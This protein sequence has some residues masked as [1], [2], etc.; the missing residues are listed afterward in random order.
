MSVE[1]SDEI[2]S[3]MWE[4]INWVNVS[5]KLDNLQEELSKA[6]KKR[7]FKEVSY[8]QKKIVRDIDIKCL[9]VRHV[10]LSSSGPGIDG[11]RW[12]TS[13]EMMKAALSLT[14]KNYHARP[15]RQI[16]IIAKNSGKERRPQIPTYYDRS[17]GVLYGYSLLPVTEALADRKSFAFRPSRSIHD[18]HAYVCEAF[19][20]SDSPEYAVIGDIDSYY[21]S[22]QHTWL[23]EHV[24]MDKKVL[25][26]FLNSGFIFAG[27]LFPR[28]DTGIS[29]G[30]NL[31]PYLGN[32]ALDGL[33]KY[34]FEALNDTEKPKDFTNGNLIRY[35]D[36]ILITARNTH[37][38][39]KILKILK[40]FLDERGLRL[41]P[42]KTKICSI[43]E[44]F[45]FLARTY[46]K[47][48][49]LIYAYPSKKAVDR[50]IDELRNTISQNKKSQRELILT[51]NR[52]LKGWANYY[53]FCDALDAFNRV[54]T[55]VQT[56][57]LEEVRLKHPKMQL[58][59]LKAKY[60]YEESDKRH[61][62]ALLD[63]KSIRVIHIAD[64]V[65]LTH[66]KIKTNVNPF[67]DREY[68]EK[69]THMRAIQNVT[70][71]F[72]TIW[73]RQAG[74]CYYCGKPIR[75]DEKKA[76]V[77]LDLSKRPSVL[78]QAYVHKA[79]LRNEFDIV[80]TMEDI[81][82][83]RPYD[84]KKILTSIMDED[85]E[86]AQKFSSLRSKPQITTKWKYYRL[87]KYFSECTR[88]SLTLRFSD[89]ED[90]IKAPLP[91]S[92]RKFSEWWYPR[93]QTNKIAEAWI[94][95]GYSCMKVDIKKEKISLKRN[96]EGKGHF[97]IPEALLNS[98]IP[99]DAVF[100][101]E[102]HMDYII[103]KYGLK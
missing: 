71:K 12:R 58:G 93:K 97:K 2:L 42:N 90:I 28:E 87:K 38:A 11:V 76:L 74:R 80:E 13:A 25:S 50:F 82:I 15:L 23:L 77:P 24:P 22:I 70:G 31:S 26:E 95:E 34:I 98:R 37:E 67:L 53:K 6:A 49:G 48:N 29:E 4:S 54:D 86:E 3:S 68:V 88:A 66:Q 35:A 89:I 72:G 102:T 69:R 96:E 61:S 51:L 1:F 32:F 16:V 36:D 91:E 52:K 103:N 84:M 45:T 55:A 64:T 17:M 20:Y 75:S 44:G 21:A 73:K 27:Q 101:L 9:A 57:L 85:L 18:A 5:K 19:K 43:R 63:D 78:N 7:D 62:F 39:N 40:N 65:L 81:D 41:S 100:E 83:L 56:I 94:T 10:V 33:Q 30:S 60:W 79:C 47:K 8:L 99:L 46:I 14:S 59:R 92:A